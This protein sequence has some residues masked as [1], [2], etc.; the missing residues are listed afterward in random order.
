MNGIEQIWN[1]ITNNIPVQHLTQNLTPSRQKFFK[2]IALAIFKIQVNFHFICKL[3]CK[4]LHKRG[5]Y[6]IHIL[7]SPHKII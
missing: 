6:T 1:V 5:I 4:I 3:C 2:G 7:H